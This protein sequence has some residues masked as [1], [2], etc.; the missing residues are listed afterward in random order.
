MYN[1]FLIL[2]FN[3]GTGLQQIVHV[4]VILIMFF[5]LNFEGAHG[6]Y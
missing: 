2:G 3:I 1:I 6:F 5:V 4:F